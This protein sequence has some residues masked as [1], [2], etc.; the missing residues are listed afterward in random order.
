MIRKIILVIGATGAQGLA[1][2]DALLAPAPLLSES[3]YTLRALTRDVRSIRARELAARGVECVQ[4]SFTDFKTVEKA[5]QGAYGVWVNTDG[6]TVGEAGEIYTGMRIFEI[7]KRVEG[8]MHFVWSNLRFVSKRAGFNPL[9]RAEHMD[10]KG[11]VGEWLSVQPSAL[12]GLVWSQ[13]TTGPYMDM[14]LSAPMFTPMNVRADGTVVFA[15]VF[16][17]GRLPLIALKDLGWWARWTF[18]HR[19]EASGKEMNVTSE[20]VS[21]DYLAATFTKVTGKP[22]IHR[23]L[24][25][26][27][28]RAHTDDGV[29]GPIATDN[30]RGDGST[31]IWENTTAFWRVLRD[32]II[33]KDMEWIKSVHPE[34]YTL[35]RWMRE[36][37]YDGTTKVLLKDSLDGNNPWPGMSVE[38]RKQL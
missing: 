28:V 18:D 9:Y 35:E 38:W 8:L 32:D 21:W 15:S 4:G 29:D 23:R 12:D 34:T 16:E 27:E 30:Q 10:G 11:R 1:V 6:F 7:A 26:D 14:L 20:C 37:R 17:D 24:T 33:D 13:V 22:A 2:I 25:I 3:P 36:N 31:T 5:L 19:V